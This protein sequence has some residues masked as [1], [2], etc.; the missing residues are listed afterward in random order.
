M[1]NKSPAEWKSQYVNTWRWASE[2]W[3]GKHGEK[4]RLLKVIDPEFLQQTL[5]GRLPLLHASASSKI[6]NI[7]FLFVI[8][9]VL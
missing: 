5:A 8:K 6:W 1:V 9:D 3:Q 2:I 7:L 4:K